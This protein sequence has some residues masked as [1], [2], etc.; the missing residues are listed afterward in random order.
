MIKKLS[1]VI[2]LIVVSACTP[3]AAVVSPP[4]SVVATL[5][6][7]A[8]AAP[9]SRAEIRWNL[10]PDAFAARGDE[11]VGVRQTVLKQTSQ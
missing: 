10:R 4:P 7:P 5:A 2:A 1:G 8:S 6:A 3:A 9:V 11:I